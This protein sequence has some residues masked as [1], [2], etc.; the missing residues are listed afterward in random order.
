MIRTAQLLYFLTTN[1]LYCTILAAVDIKL[2]PIAFSKG[3]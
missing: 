3:G 2:V 1:D